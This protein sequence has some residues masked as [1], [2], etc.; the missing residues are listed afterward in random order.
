MKKKKC[1]PTASVIRLYP[2]WRVTGFG[3][4][5]S[6]S[7]ALLGACNVLT[8]NWKKMAMTITDNTDN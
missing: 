4:I 8:I 5:L 3:Q 7:A 6:A 2:L 1:K